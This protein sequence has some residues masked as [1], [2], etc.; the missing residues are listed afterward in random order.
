MSLN[1]AEVCLSPD[2]GG[3]ELYMVRAAQA[4]KTGNRVISII[5]ANGALADFFEADDTVIAL[6]RGSVLTRLLLAKKIAAI[7]DAHEID[8]IHVHWTKDLFTVVLAKQFAKRSVAIAQT[9][10]MTMTRF[11]DDWFHRFIYARIARMLPVTDQVK[12][13]I[14]QFIPKDIRPDVQRLYMGTPLLELLSEQER[15]Q[16]REA[17]GISQEQFLIGMVGRIEKG[18]GQYLL[19]EAVS[20]LKAKGIAVHAIFVGHAMDDAYLQHLKDDVAT[21]ALDDQ[22]HFVGFLRSPNHFMQCCDTV[23]LATQRETFGLVL[24]EAMAAHTAVIG[25][26][27][28]GVLEIIEDKNSGLLF[29]TNNALALTSAIE[30][31]YHDKPFRDAVANAGYERVKTHFCATEQFEKLS[32]L[33]QG[34]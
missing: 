13:Q 22:I 18:K 29:E 11:K 1:I 14:E 9:R 3:L 20:Q 21:K 27:S 16:Q 15:M 33:L 31:L 8:V 2:K 5:N 19:I 25:A 28:G 23:V 6:E 10:N 7:L 17:L 26:D 4:L 30:K 12:A 34:L 24:I 32:R